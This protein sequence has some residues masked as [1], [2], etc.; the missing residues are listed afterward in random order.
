MADPSEMKN[1]Q[2]SESTSSPGLNGIEATVFSTLL[3]AAAVHLARLFFSAHHGEFYREE[4]IGI[5][6]ASLVVVVLS[7]LVMRQRGGWLALVVYTLCFVSILASGLVVT[8]AFLHGLGTV[9]V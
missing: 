2:S 3:L 8:F 9:F 7:A 6:L 4:G 1:S 5:A